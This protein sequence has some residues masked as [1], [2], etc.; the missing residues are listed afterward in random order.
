MALLSGSK[1]RKQY[2]HTV[3]KKQHT[4]LPPDHWWYRMVSIRWCCKKTTLGLDK[5]G[6]IAYNSIIKLIFLEIYQVL[7][8]YIL[9]KSQMPV[10]DYHS[11]IWGENTPALGSG[12]C[13]G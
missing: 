7:S 11:F 6:Y 12:D 8:C 10:V 4:P 9:H 1:V 5:V 2:N 13:I 3:V